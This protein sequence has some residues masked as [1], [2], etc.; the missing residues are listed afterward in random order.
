MVKTYLD[1]LSERGIRPFLTDEAFEELQKFDYKSQYA[2]PGQVM[3]VF[4]HPNQHKIELGKTT[5]LIGD[6]CWYGASV[7]ELVRSIKYGMVVL[8][9]DKRHLDWKKAA[10]DFGIQELLK[11]YRRFRRKPKLTERE[12]ACHYRLYRL[13]SGGYGRKGSGFRGTGAG[14]F[15][16]DAGAA[17]SPGCCGGAPGF[18]GGILRDLPEAP[19]L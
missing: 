7:E 11:E 18:A 6:M 1:I 3:P 8:D 15:H 9:A 5:N 10:E 2:I 12:K 17:R 16:S 13:C 4:K 19:H 14:S